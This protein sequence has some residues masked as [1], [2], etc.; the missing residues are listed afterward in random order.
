M[1][2]TTTASASQVVIVLAGLIGSGKSTFAKALELYEPTFVRC[3]QDELGTRRDV[4]A[5]V[6]STLQSGKSVIV[7]RTNIDPGQRRTWI[8]IG[9]Q[10]PGTEIWGLMLDTPMSVCTA[11]I[12]TRT[13]HPTITSPELGLSVLSRFAS[14]FQPMHLS[15]GFDLLSSLAP[16]PSPIYTAEDIATILA[17]IRALP[18]TPKRYVPPGRLANNNWGGRGGGMGSGI[19]GGRG[20]G[21]RNGGMGGGWGSGTGNGGIGGGTSN[22]WGSGR[23]GWRGDGDKGRGRGYPR[24]GQPQP[25]Q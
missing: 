1:A 25:G 14:E 12:Q 4:E 5:L 8:D 17:R 13:D 20:S 6:R 9:R 3:N 24:R 21:M 2:S 7:D 16:R 10:F 18:R 22:E 23:G 15:E 11:R 19:S